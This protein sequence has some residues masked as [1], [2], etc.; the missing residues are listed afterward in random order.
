M[1][2]IHLELG[3]IGLIVVSLLEIYMVITLG[4]NL[5]PYHHVTITSV[6]NTNHVEA[7]NTP[8]QNVLKLVYLNME[9]NTL[10]IKTM[11]KAITQLALQL[12]QSKLKS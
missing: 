11:V 6:E 4:V 3:D 12:N 1:E 8:L 10:K 5:T 2:V 9:N 7:L